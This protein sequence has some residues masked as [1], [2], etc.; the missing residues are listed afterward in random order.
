LAAARAIRAWEAESG[1]PRSRLVALTADVVP[2][3]QEAARAPGIDKILEKPVSPD[4]LR[5]LLA[6]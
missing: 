2:E 1:G 3:T 4:T 6:D 5:R